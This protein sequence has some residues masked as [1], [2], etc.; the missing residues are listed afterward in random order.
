MCDTQA[1][2]TCYPFSQICHPAQQICHPVERRDPG[3]VLRRVKPQQSCR[4]TRA[5]QQPLNLNMKTTVTEI[6]VSHS[7]GAVQHCNRNYRVSFKGCSPVHLIISLMPPSISTSADC[8]SSPC[9]TSGPS[10]KSRCVRGSNHATG[11][12]CRNASVASHPIR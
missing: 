8:R 1:P 10:V 3:K 6:I 9:P 5:N 4:R 12:I 2:Q 7:R 11:M